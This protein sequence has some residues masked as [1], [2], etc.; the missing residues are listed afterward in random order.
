MEMS[1]KQSDIFEAAKNV[2][3]TLLELMDIPASVTLS[4]EFTV[5][6]E[7]GATLFCWS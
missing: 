4:D 3:E 1:E 5:E 2:L 6:D 7:E